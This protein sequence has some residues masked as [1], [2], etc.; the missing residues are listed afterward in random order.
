MS[1]TLRSVGASVTAR[2]PAKINLYLEVGERQPDGYHPLT[3]VFQAVSLLDDVTV[4]EAGATSVEAHGEGVG[5]VPTDD[6]NL[7]V[8]AAHALAR[9]VGRQA[10]VQI[11]LLKGIP[12][13]GGMGGGSAD[14]AAAL[15]ACDAL[16][17]TN[18]ERDELLELASTLGADVPFCLTGGTA[19]GTGRGDVLTPVLARGTY[20][21]ILA[22]ADG[23]LSTPEV[24]AEFDRGPRP[25]P[26]RGQVVADGPGGVLTALRSYDPVALGA[27][28]RN[29]LQPPALRL[30][31]EL[32]Q[33]LRAAQDLDCLGA[34]VSGS[35]PTV[36]MLCR[37]GEHALSAAAELSGMG[38]CR[39]VRRAHGPVPGAKLVTD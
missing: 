26:R 17:R 39:T 30:K 2:A 20:H 38:V 36:A 3:T 32:Q 18:V 10:F 25:E 35:G 19:L 22:L 12:V 16:W 9:H 13:A 7:A 28:L 14:A 8:R 31:P 29:D 11:D 21:W 33:V 15:L 34:V 6:G 37:D 4:T 5:D 27:S 1:P 24:Y 23:G